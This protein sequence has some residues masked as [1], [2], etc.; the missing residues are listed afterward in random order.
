MAFWNRFAFSL[1]RFRRDEAGAA[2]VELVAAVS[3]L[4]V[5]AAGTGDMGERL[6]GQAGLEDAT[7]GV[8]A[9]LARA[10]AGADGGVT[11]AAARAAEAAMRVRLDALGLRAAALSPAPAGATCL[12]DG[13]LC[14]RVA[15][16][17]GAEAALGAPR[18]VVQV[19]AGADPGPALRPVAAGASAPASEGAPLV[20]SAARMGAT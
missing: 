15:R 10:P 19:W 6:R 8:A 7:A 4:L 2:A 5:F 17:E 16:A 3:V 11:E 14:Y 9:M 13:A 20:A 1:A 12:S 18:R